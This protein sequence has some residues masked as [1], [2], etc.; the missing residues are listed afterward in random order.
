MELELE[1]E[2]LELFQEEN[3][4]TGGCDMISCGLISCIDLLSCGAYTGAQ[5]QL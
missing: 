1:L 3:A 2:A 5:T 4:L